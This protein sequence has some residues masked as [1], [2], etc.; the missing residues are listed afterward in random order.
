MLFRP[1]FI[2]A[3]DVKNIASLA[4]SQMMAE[5]VTVPHLLGAATHVSSIE[6]YVAVFK[7]VFSTLG[8]TDIIEPEL[9]K[10]P[11]DIILPGDEFQ[12]SFMLSSATYLRPETTWYTKSINL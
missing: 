3:S 11:S 1:S 9:R 5:G 6:E 2:E 7:R 8:F 4:I 12:A 10:T